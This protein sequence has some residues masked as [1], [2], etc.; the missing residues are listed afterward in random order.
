MKKRQDIEALLKKC[1]NVVMTDEERFNQRVS[2]VY[3]NINISRHE[4]GLPEIPREE[5]ERMARELD[6]SDA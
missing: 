2:F 5:V 4:R 1:R 3:G 6:A